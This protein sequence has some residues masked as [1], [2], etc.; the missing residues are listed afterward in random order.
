[1]GGGPPPPPPGETKSFAQAA[2]PHKPA[3]EK[4]AKPF[5][6]KP[7][8]PKTAQ[9]NAGKTRKAVQTPDKDA[10]AA[11]QKTTKNA[12]EQIVEP[13]NSAEGRQSL[14]VRRLA[15]PSQGDYLMTRSPHGAKRNAGQPC[16]PHG[17]TRISL[18]S[19]R[20]TSH[21]WTYI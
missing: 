4:A 7:Q 11:A 10:K 2:P 16:R 20:A 9:T 18:R 19:I 8:P 15:N 14:Q 5:A 1:N 13:Q 21:S 17:R 3:K 6:V 12:R